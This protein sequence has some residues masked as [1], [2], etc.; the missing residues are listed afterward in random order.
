M[1][2]DG[3]RALK[4]M[5][6]E[7]FFAP[8][9]PK[10]HHKV[11]SIVLEVSGFPKHEITN[12]FSELNKSSQKEF[13]LRDLSVLSPTSL[14]EIA[15]GKTSHALVLW[16]LLNRLIQ[17]HANSCDLQGSTEYVEVNDPQALHGD[18]PITELGLSARS[19]NTLTRKG[20]DSAFKLSQIS[21]EELF[22][23]RN[24]G[25]RSVNEILALLENI[26]LRSYQ[27][28]RQEPSFMLTNAKDLDD[29]N[30]TTRTYNALKRTGIRNLAELASLTEDELRDI[31]NFGEKSITEVKDLVARHV[32]INP[33]LDGETSTQSSE[34]SDSLYQWVKK[35]LAEEISSMKSGISEFLELKLNMANW[36]GLPLVYSDCSTV[37]E[38][39]EKLQVQL[40]ES[41]NPQS[42]DAVILNLN[43]LS[44]DLQTLR[45]FHSDFMP[46]R[47]QR[48]SLLRY[49]NEYS[50]DSVD[51]LKFDDFTL[52]LLGIT[53]KN[54]SLFL[55]KESYF[56]LLDTVFEYF[57]MNVDVWNIIKQ[58][59]KFHEKHGTYPNTIGII[60]AHHMG[61]EE[62]K[63]EVQ[64]LLQD[65]LIE[66]RPNSAERDLNILQMRISGATLDEIGKS[67]DV[68]RERVRQILVKI[69]PDLVRT[70]EAL[71]FGIQKK[72]EKIN[73]KK[74]A[75][76][77]E[78]YGAIYKS[79]LALELG[80]DEETALQSTPKRF[81]K[82][83]IDKFPEPLVSLAWTREDCLNALRRAGTYYFPIRQADYDH[84]LNIGEIKGP[85]IQY[86]YLKFGQWTELCM[87]AGVEC[88]PSVRSEYVRMW[89]DEELLSYAR[90]FLKEEGTSGSY[91]GYDAWRELQPDHVPSGVLIRNVFGNWTTVKRK[92]L[93]GLRL[94]KGLDVR[95]DL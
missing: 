71:R 90:R 61:G 24:L 89:S 79:E 94:E 77:F 87:E 47:E 34:T 55:G 40:G 46:T 13:E 43:T 28:Q 57:I 92:A 78:K 12:L 68:T 52:G 19:V 16:A 67:V 31:R 20:I 48:D 72:Q 39:V 22:D 88:V 65:I 18:V 51:L 33:P 25:I 73:E 27:S 11:D 64:Q 38:V 8:I 9:P 23:M 15:G 66:M 69:S 63:E 54:S 83:I 3:V 36:K 42:V 44:Q 29:L 41:N 95:S 2:K 56:E 10:C 37:A 1:F 32:L 70:I 93:E 81:N 30:L 14:R 6:A 17:F 74:Y 82:F 62:Q 4:S 49:E 45:H 26:G 50:D 76:L 84:L 80:V 53:S 35:E 60:I 58:T 5:G 85:S 59:I 7:N 86:M 91:G 75:D 21:K